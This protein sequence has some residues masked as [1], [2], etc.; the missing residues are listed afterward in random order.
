MLD[1]TIIYEMFD[2]LSHSLRAGNYPNPRLNSKL[3]TSFMRFNYRH[4]FSLVLR[5]NVFS[6]LCLLVSGGRTIFRSP[7]SSGDTQYGL[8]IQ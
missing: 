3:C 6:I 4:I 7:H 5:R 1:K 2:R 8:M